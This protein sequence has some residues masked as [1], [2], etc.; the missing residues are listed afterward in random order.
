LVLHFIP[1][2]RSMMLTKSQIKKQAKQERIRAKYAAK[3]TEK[4]SAPIAS[5]NSSAPNPIRQERKAMIRAEFESNCQRGP[6]VIIDCEWYTH[7][8]P[9]ELLSLTQQIM[10][11]Y[12]SNKDAKRPVRLCI[13]GVSEE[14][15]SMI[16]KLPGFPQWYVTITTETLAS[17]VGKETTDTSRFTYLTADSENVLD[18]DVVGPADTLVIGGLVDRNRLKNAT[19]TKAAELGIRAAQLPI[20]EYMQMRSSK[21][22]TVNH[23]VEILTEVLDHRDWG[24]ALGKVI[25]DRK[26][27]ID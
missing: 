23:V 5:T 22:L 13:V 19:A 10:Y 17:L 3:K 24:K 9:K 1:N 20:G 25:P 15:C 12:A 6:T 11:S 2:Y 18:I 8:S 26:K 4:I 27:D 14:H 16:K 7:M 21:V